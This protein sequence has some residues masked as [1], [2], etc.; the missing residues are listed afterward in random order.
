MLRVNAAAD[1]VGYYRKT[2]WYRANWDK[3]EMKGIAENTVQMEKVL[4]D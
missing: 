2:G 1:A 3:T 4:S